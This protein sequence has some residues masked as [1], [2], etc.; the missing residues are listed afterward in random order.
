MCK[1]IKYIYWVKKDL[2]GLVW[3][4]WLCRRHSKSN[5]LIKIIMTITTVLHSRAAPSLEY[6]PAEEDDFPK[7]IP[8]LVPFF[9]NLF[10]AFAASY[11]PGPG[12]PL[13]RLLTF[14][15]WDRLVISTW[16]GLD[17]VEPGTPVKNINFWTL[18]R[19]KV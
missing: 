12:V 19:K 3:K 14:L 18:K 1:S 9:L 7:D 16:T 6:L 11:S 5:Q 15:L 13:L 4:V 10:F 8:P 2:F 17:H